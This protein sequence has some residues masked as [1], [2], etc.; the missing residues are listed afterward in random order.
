MNLE[1]IR[2]RTV[3]AASSGNAANV[4]KEI[5]KEVKQTQKMQAEPKEQ[6]I[7][8]SFTT[9]AKIESKSGRVEFLNTGFDLRDG[10][11]SLG[12][13]KLNFQKIAD[14][15]QVA[16]GSFYFSFDEFME[17]EE[18][19]RTDLPQKY[20]ES[21]S[22]KVQENTKY[23]SA[24]YSSYKK[25]EKDGK[26]YSRIFEIAP[27]ETSDIVLS[28]KLGP[29]VLDEKTKQ[30]R[31]SGKME[32]IISVPVSMNRLISIINLVRCEI[33]AYKSSVHTVRKMTE[34]FNEKI[35][36]I[37]IQNKTILS[38]VNKLLELSE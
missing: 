21:L 22:K 18:F 9:I 6:Q 8:D 4:K 10:G 12:K 17:L 3:A 13:V 32:V 2:L 24:I 26:I 33:I 5:K 29:G 36:M 19:I 11:T 27:S 30:V 20:A 34:S 28:Y 16:F 31:P 35:N 1:A 23:A 15:K 14:N 37:E 38:K 25:Y 7:D